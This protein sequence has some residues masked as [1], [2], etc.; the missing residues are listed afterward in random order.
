MRAVKVRQGENGRTSSRVA[1][2]PHDRGL[3]AVEVIADREE[4]ED[5]AGILANKLACPQAE[6]G[7]IGERP[8]EDPVE[9]RHLGRVLRIMRIRV[10]ECLQRAYEGRSIYSSL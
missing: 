8:A 2:T 1:L 9:D 7:I 5:I 4:R 3:R 10:D 6:G